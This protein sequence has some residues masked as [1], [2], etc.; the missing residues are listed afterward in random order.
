MNVK[1]TPHF[2]Y[3][4]LSSLAL[5]LS[6]LPDCK[7][8]AWYYWFYEFICFSNPLPTDQNPA[9]MSLTP[10]HS[11]HLHYK[12]DSHAHSTHQTFII[13]FLFANLWFYAPLHCYFMLVTFSLL[14]KLGL[15]SDL[16][17]GSFILLYCFVSSS[18]Y[19]VLLIYF[20][21]FEFIVIFD[22]YLL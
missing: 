22:W 11:L 6:T 12:A 18:F 20:I 13:H 4:S 9:P 16:K 3:G 5:P 17:I 2:M 14:Q 1:I 8:C 10:S 21:T 15:K 7:N 19:M